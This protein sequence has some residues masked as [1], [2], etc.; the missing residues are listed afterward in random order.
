MTGEG[1]ERALHNSAHLLYMV[2]FSTIFTSVREKEGKIVD[3]R[4]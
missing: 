1:M 2:V 3:P 4:V